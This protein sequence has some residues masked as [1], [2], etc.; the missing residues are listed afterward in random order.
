[1]IDR[2][3]EIW[4]TEGPVALLQSVPRY[5]YWQFGIRT[6][7]LRASYALSNSS[8]TISMLNSETIFSTETYAEFVRVQTLM[9][10]V[11]MIHDLCEE[12]RSDDIFYDIG[13]NV[14]VYSCLA[15][16]VTSEGE[17]VAF[18][19]HPDNIKSLNS[20][21]NRNRINATVMEIA[22]SDENDR[23]V[24][25]EEGSGAGHGEHQITE[26][27][28]NDGI[29][30]N[31]RSLDEV[32]HV[33]ELPQPN[34]LKIDVEGAEYD[35]IKGGLQTLSRNDCRL[36]Y[37]EIHPEKVQTFGGSYDD[38]VDTL[39]ECGFAIVDTFGGEGTSNPMIKA[40]R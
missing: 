1:M 16:S 28:T 13:A 17:V 19:P 29:R 3:V 40:T 14:G 33:E 34:V 35:V 37:C 10:E 11:E 5:I 23:L 9:N 26:E 20:N 15:G 32:R 2:A 18:E 21:I 4:N 12:L 31:V 27:S 25:A 8:T 39:A 38:V 22:L 7:H 24:L 30:I 36:V 6:L